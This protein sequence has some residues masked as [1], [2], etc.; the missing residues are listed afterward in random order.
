MFYIEHAPIYEWKWNKQKKTLGGHFK[1][2]LQEHLHNTGFV[3]TYF[4]PFLSDGF[5]I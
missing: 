3:N 2:S 1:F 4:A 5:L